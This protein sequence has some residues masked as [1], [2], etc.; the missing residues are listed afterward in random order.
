MEQLRQ[1]E[2]DD[3]EGVMNQF[4]NADGSI[5]AHFNNTVTAFF[6]YLDESEDMTKR[7]VCNAISFLAYELNKQTHIETGGIAQHGYV[8]RIQGVARI[9]KKYDKD[10]R[11]AV[12]MAN[13]KIIKFVDLH[14]KIDTQMPTSMPII[15]R[16]LSGLGLWRASSIFLSILCQKSTAR[17]TSKKD[18]VL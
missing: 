3:E 5:A 9:K 15:A 14:S 7:I 1:S 18:L 16:I 12:K 4:V 10:D 13:G 6:K 8:S 17:E 11:S 2:F